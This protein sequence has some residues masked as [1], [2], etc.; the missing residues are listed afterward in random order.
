MASA[1][2]FRINYKSDF[3]L[4]LESDAGW[5][6][7]FC[8]KFWTGAPSQAYYVGWDGET[9]DHC[10]FDPSE[11][12]KL[13]VQFDDHHLPIGDLK[14]Q[15]AYHFTVADFPND[16]EDEVINPANITT[17]IDGETYQVMLDFT[18]E[19]APEIQF[20]LPAYANEAQRIANE[21]QRIAS[22]TQRIANEETRIANEQ[23]RINQEQ[24]RQQNEQQRINQE[25]AR[26]NEY[27]TLKADAVAATDAA[28]DAAAMANQKAQLAADK[29]AL[30]QDAA[31][32]A[33]AKA[34]LAADKAALAASAAQLA[35][36]KAALAQQKAEY[37]Q[38]Q[39]GYAKDQGDYAKDQGDYAKAQGD[40]SKEQ[41]DYAKDQGD[42]AKDKGDICAEDHQ[43]AVAD[44]Q[45]AV[46]D[47]QTAQSDHTQA[48]ND[49]TRAESDHG[50][51]AADHTQAGNDHTRAE[52]DHTRAESD[53]AAVEVYVDSLGAFDISAYH[54]TGG[55]LAKYADLTAALGT[56]GANI[57]DALRKGGMSVKYVQTSD[58]KYVQYRLMATA[59]STNVANWQG[60]DKKA[61]KS[62]KNI[63]DSNGV[64]NF[65][66]EYACLYNT[67]P[68]LDTTNK[69]FK[70]P[71]GAFIAS[72]KGAVAATENDITWNRSDTAAFYA[73]YLILNV[74]DFTH[75]VMANGHLPDC[76]D[77]EVVI[78]LVDWTH[79]VIKCNVGQYKKDGK[80]IDNYQKRPFDSELIE[81]SP[82]HIS[83]GVVKAAFDK[84]IFNSNYH[85]V[86]WRNGTIEINKVQPEG[87]SYY[88]VSARVTEKCVFIH[89]NGK[90]TEFEPNENFISINSGTTV[91][92]GIN[93]N[94]EL[95]FETLST[96]N[97]GLTE[98][99]IIFTNSQVDTEAILTD[100]S[101][102]YRAHIV[103]NGVNKVASEWAYKNIPPTIENEVTYNFKSLD[104]NKT[105][106][107]YVYFNKLASNLIRVGSRKIY[108][109]ARKKFFVL[110]NQSTYTYQIC[111][112]SSTAIVGGYS[113]APR[114]FTVPSDGI[115]II[116]LK[117]GNN[118][119][120]TLADLEV[121]N[122]GKLYSLF[123]YDEDLVTEN[124][125]L[126]Q[127]NIAN[128][129]GSTEFLDG[130]FYSINPNDNPIT[131]QGLTANAAMTCCEVI[132]RPGTK[133]YTFTPY[134]SIAYLDENRNF[135]DGYYYNLQT[136]QPDIV[137]RVSDVPWNTKYAQINTR[138]SFK[139]QTIVTE[140]PFPSVGL[141]SY[142]N[143][144]KQ[145]I[146]QSQILHQE[147]NCIYDRDKFVSNAGQN[148]LGFSGTVTVDSDSNLVLS[149]NTGAYI[150]GLHTTLDKSTVGANV[151]VTTIPSSG[152]IVRFGYYG[153]A[154]VGTAITNADTWIDVFADKV[155]LYSG[156]ITGNVSTLK[157][158]ANLSENIAVNDEIEL[159]IVKDSVYHHV[160]KIMKRYVVIG[161][162][163]LTA[164]VDPNDSD[165]EYDQMRSWGAPA[166][167]S[168]TD[169]SILVSRLFFYS[170]CPQ[171]A[172]L[173]IV[174]DSY[175]ENQSRSKAAGWVRLLEDK[176]GSENLF[177]SGQ[178]GGN[179]NALL[180]KLPIELN[181]CRPKYVILH[182]GTN[183]AG[184]GTETQ[185]NTYKERLLQLID[186]VKAVNAIPILM[187]TPRIQNGSN[188]DL[189]FIT[190]INPWIKSLGYKYVDIAYCLSTG[191]GVTMD[192][193]RM[194][195]DLVH[196]NHLGAEAILNWVENNL[197]MIL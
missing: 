25:Q 1:K 66:G 9:Y 27:A 12:T 154:V 185:I 58:N 157:G 120:F 7:P 54:A 184:T 44:H 69:S 138:L 164:Y 51:A 45:T 35:N 72:K 21:Q 70:L 181:L 134:M 123:S 2:I 163:E 146:P 88:T 106:I 196:P 148:E 53:H 61:T 32:L 24:T 135:I 31:N 139:Y 153:S 121:I 144:S 190:T 96:S 78:A 151:K 175:V 140:C 149:S 59:W 10:S 161:E 41:G 159:K 180:T 81:N 179:A 114:I 136:T 65:I 43:T 152:K 57:P 26:V 99:T 145:L 38:T 167:W 172:K 63:I 64:Y 98:I 174:G 8:I 101:S 168:G 30:A 158:T 115:I 60:I 14:Y 39:G 36:D 82:N 73:G 113:N 191:D 111:D 192:T 80:L 3:I 52:S 108:L 186:M 15:V 5:M 124:S 110:T 194:R 128:L 132:V 137:P 188:D 97:P 16:T 176:I 129:W 33:N 47:H 71:S 89:H 17:E 171:Y 142:R 165:H 85:P 127:D 40:Y 4:T 107:G 94:G 125:V 29:A 74:S 156:N 37:A 112:S 182:T 155:E 133:L 62:S 116:M 130:Y 23:T 117:K 19:T 77:N 28:N 197:H 84:Y 56:N 49:H 173:A 92:L 166:I 147:L 122:D 119:E 86:F 87:E 195:P 75:R 105:F 143:V 20:A 13:Q 11:P 131:Y 170:N 42:Y 83:S 126:K 55:V 150:R 6:T 18:G 162:I 91:V 177:I 187:T 68:E 193:N 178:G 46:A 118:E 34:Q 183:D 76:D 103:Y 141:E 104:Y 169:A 93:D 90:I 109:G 95:A 100:I 67:I 22:E 160:V 50:I 48:G 189:N 79:D 102:S